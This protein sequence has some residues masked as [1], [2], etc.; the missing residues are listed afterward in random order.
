MPLEIMRSK[1][2]DEAIH[3]EGKRAE[4]GYS[5]TKSFGLDKDTD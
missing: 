4:S 1:H 5:C 2:L 3:R